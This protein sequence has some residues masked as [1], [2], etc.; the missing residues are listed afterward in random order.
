MSDPQPSSEVKERGVVM[1]TGI[2]T[3]SD[4]LALLPLP[5][6]DELTA[7][8]ARGAVCVWDPT[9]PLLTAV[10]AVDLG[11]RLEEVHL[12]PRACRRHTGDHAHRALLDHVPACEECT[13]SRTIC[14]V[15]R[16]LYRLALRRTATYG[17]LDVPAM[18]ETAREVLDG[19][20]PV[21]EDR[22]D[23]VTSRLRGHLMMA[24]PAVLDAA[25][26]YPE[27]DIPAACALVGVEDARLRLDKEPAA[28]RAAGI[29][30]A[31][32]LARSVMALCDHYQS[33]TH[34]PV[35]HA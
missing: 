4:V 21:T 9:E 2:A 26:T 3:A 27:G 22:L 12:F 13:E 23:L 24:V 32:L 20:E 35:S 18:R 31:Q 8:Q 14:D 5:A 6:Q 29:A 30:H 15:G 33:L 19:A 25:T 1:R 10:T 17:A 34:E 16:V 7:D 11:E 28:T